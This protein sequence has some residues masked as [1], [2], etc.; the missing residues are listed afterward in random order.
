MLGHC[1]LQLTDLTLIILENDQPMGE[2]LHCPQCQL[3]SSKVTYVFFIYFLFY[4]TGL[5]FGC[6]CK[7]WLVTIPF[8]TLKPH[9]LLV[10]S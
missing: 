3:E 1:F 2:I 9:W 5:I 4:F 7:S 6:D 8:E 10:N